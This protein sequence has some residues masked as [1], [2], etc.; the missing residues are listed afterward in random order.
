M[1]NICAGKNKRHELVY[2]K[3]AARDEQHVNLVLD[4][5]CKL[6][7]LFDLWGAFNYI[8][9][10]QAVL[11]GAVIADFGADGVEQLDCEAAA[12][13]KFCAPYSSVRLLK[14]GLN[15][16]AGADRVHRGH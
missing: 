14:T 15:S 3:A 4:N 16:S 12:V 5:L 7:D 1:I 13:F 6:D 8:R 11:D 2:C 9:A 10:T